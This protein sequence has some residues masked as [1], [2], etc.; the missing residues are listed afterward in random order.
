MSEFNKKKLMLLGLRGEKGE[1]GEKGDPGEKGEKGDPFNFEDLTD[2]QQAELSAG[3][4]EECVRI[5]KGTKTPVAV[6]QT[7]KQFSVIFTSKEP[8]V[9]D[10]IG[11]IFGVRAEITEDGQFLYGA[12]M[13]GTGD[14]YVTGSVDDL[15]LGQPYKCTSSWGDLAAIDTVRSEASNILIYNDELETTDAAVYSEDGKET[16]VTA[17]MV[18]ATTADYVDKKAAA[19]AEEVKTV[20][21]I[22]KGAQQALSFGDYYSAV[23]TVGAVGAD[24]YN[25]GQSLLIVT[26]EVPDLWVS[27]VSDTSVAYEYTTD[28]AFV[29]KLKETGSVQVGHYILSALETQ[30]VNLQNYVEKYTGTPAQSTAVCYVVDN[31]DGERVDDTFPVSINAEGWT[32]ARR[33]DGGRLATGTPTASTDATPKSYVD[34]K[35]ATVTLPKLP[36]GADATTYVTTLTL[37]MNGHAKYRFLPFNIDGTVDGVR[38]PLVNQRVFVSKTQ[39]DNI[40][41]VRERNV[42]E[43]GVIKHQYVNAITG[44]YDSAT[45]TVTLTLPA[46][47]VWNVSPEWDAQALVLLTD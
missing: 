25:V 5:K 27:G 43:N 20:E 11:D 31:V 42:V 24:V 19:L 26:L 18:G 29:E 17:D 23:Q 13:S 41:F 44:A 12:Y 38:Y 47:E 32:I 33:R 9:T 40:H 45:D 15:V 16:P 1:K 34:T 28:D 35:F 46:G 39:T 22:A 7:V 2:E 30:K 37:K 6:G 10:Y 36:A 21:S 14:D 3:M 4:S 8:G